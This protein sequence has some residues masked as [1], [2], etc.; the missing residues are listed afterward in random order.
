M[1]KVKL[2]GILG[3]LIIAVLLAG[4]SARE[5]IQQ[6][7]F[8]VQPI[9]EQNGYF[10]EDELIE[11]SNTYLKFVRQEGDLFLFYTEI[12]NNSEDTLAVYPQEIYLE[13][14][15]NYNEQNDQ[16]ADRYFAIDPAHEIEL[17][18]KQLEEE[19]NRHEGATAL[20]VFFGVF[21]TVVDLASDIGNKAEVVANDILNTG[22]NQVNEEIYH[23]DSKKNLEEIKTFWMNDMLNESFICPGDTARGL[24]YL[25]Y[26][27]TAETFKVVIPVCGFPDSFMFR[28][29]QT[30]K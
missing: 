8:D 4:C 12:K 28:Q 26:S 3:L 29:Y 7:L 10:S 6:P 13:V 22:A 17:T 16:N 24:L 15:K 18:D 23:S 2:A 20:N 21:S 1:L 11:C 14:V 5:I 27:N 9:E 19:S 25:P 30:N